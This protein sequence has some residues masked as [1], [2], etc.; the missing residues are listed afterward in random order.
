MIF[1]VSDRALGVGE[2]VVS[3]ALD[4][5]VVE[6]ATGTF[7]LLFVLF[8]LFSWGDM[9]VTRGVTWMSPGLVTGMSPGAGDRDVARGLVTQM[10][11]GVVYAWQLFGVDSSE[12]PTGSLSTVSSTNFAFALGLHPMM[13]EEAVVICT[14]AALRV[15]DVRYGNEPMRGKLLNKPNHVTAG[16]M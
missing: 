14:M 15:V 11:P 6:K 13:P 3:A 8:L 16:A 2:A 12:K 7:P 5:T 9:G 4:V 10:S 1:V